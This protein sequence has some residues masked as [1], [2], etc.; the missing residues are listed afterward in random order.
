[1]KEAWLTDTGA[2]ALLTVARL[3]GA[4]MQACR[5]ALC[6]VIDGLCFAAGTPVQTPE[7]LRE[8]ESIKVG[9]A[10]WA[11]DEENGQ[12]VARRVVELSRHQD[13]P[14][15]EV[16]IQNAFGLIESIVATPNHPFFVHGEGW[17]EA[18]DLSVGQR[19]QTHEQ[20]FAQVLQVSQRSDL[21]TVYNFTVEGVHNYFVG[22]S[23][24]LVHNA[25]SQWAKILFDSGRGVPSFL[26]N[27]HA[28]H[29]VMK[30]AFNRWLATNSAPI[31]AS[32]DILT[33]YGI[34]VF[35][36]PA[37]LT[38]AENAGHS[39]QYATKVFDSLRKVDVPGATASDI[40][41]EFI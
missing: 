11:W 41:A 27:P 39:A 10:V 19:L 6:G 1:M 32:Q 30:G 3:D 37:N 8:I 2:R 13:R 18:R 25:C 38:W 7:G 28:H 33:K 5:G 24:V 26:K 14:V 40:T 34:D 29:I 9:D 12:A 15:V 4:A 36:S 16:R 17:V 31:R 23:D 21:Q 35:T 22:E 20:S